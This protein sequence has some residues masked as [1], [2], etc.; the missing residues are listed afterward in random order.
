MKVGEYDVDAFVLEVDDDGS[1]DFR[2]E[3]GSGLAI[4][5]A[6][7]AAP[8]DRLRLVLVEHAAMHVDEPDLREDPFVA[9]FPRTTWQG[10]GDVE[11]VT[12]ELNHTPP[13]YQCVVMP[14]GRAPVVIE[15]PPPSPD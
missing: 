5:W 4:F 12:L 14:K 8:G 7:P 10:S 13:R 11:H 2:L 9:D 6:L 1:F 3:L 15:W